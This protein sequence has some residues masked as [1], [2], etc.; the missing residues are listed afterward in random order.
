MRRVASGDAVAYR[1]L[2]DTHLRSILAYGQR[3][4][5][6]LPEAE[7]V[8]QETFLRAWQNA[9]RYRPEARIST[10]LHAIAHNLCVDRLRRRRVV[11]VGDAVDEASDSQRKPSDLYERKESVLGVRRALLLLPERQ[12]AALTL[13]HYQGLTH[14]QAGEVLGIGV[15]AVESLVMRARRNLKVALAP[16]REKE[17]GDR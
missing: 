3:F 5:G 13:I 6:S 4:L 9:D 8:A 15:E 12:R 1:G 14:A 2:V 10:W 17:P 7:E 11:P 16:R